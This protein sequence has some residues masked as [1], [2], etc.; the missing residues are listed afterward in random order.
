MK[1]CSNVLVEYSGIIALIIVYSVIL[2]NEYYSILQDLG[3][4]ETGSKPEKCLG[5]SA[6]GVIAPEPVHLLT[7]LGGF[8]IYAKAPQSGIPARRNPHFPDDWI[9]LPVRGAVAL[10]IRL[11]SC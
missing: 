7:L 9:C 11:G 10:S 1:Y 8:G 4:Q 3:L 6:C 2:L 5:I